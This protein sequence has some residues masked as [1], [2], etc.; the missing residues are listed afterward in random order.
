MAGVTHQTDAQTLFAHFDGIDA[1][2]DSYDAARYSV[3][4]AAELLRRFTRAERRIVAGK[5]L[6]AARVA[7]GQL[8]LR[9]GHRTAAEFLA[10]ETGDSVGDAKDL[11]A[12][13]ASLHHQPGLEEAFRG[14]K[15][16]RRRAALVSSAVKVN[17]GQE[18]RLV[19]GAERDTLTSLRGQC[20][21]A[22]AQGRSDQD[23]ARHDRALHT[24]RRCRTFTDAE[25][26]FR[27]DALLTPDVGARV[28]S[29]LEAQAHRYFDQ[30]R[31]TGRWET[32]DAYRADALVALVTGQGILAPRRRT[33]A[34]PGNA[35]PDNAT[36]DNGT[37]TDNAAATDATPTPT[38]RTPDPRATLFI[39][40]D[41][42]ALRRGRVEGDE[43]CEIPGVGPVPVRWVTE[44]LGTALTH[45]V[46]TDGVD[47]TTLYSPGRHL[48]A[49]IR[50]ALMERDS[51]CVVP[52][53]DAR[54]GLENDHWVTDFARGGRTSLDNLARLCRH[55]HRL[56]THRGFQLLGGP[57]KWQWVA[58][59]NPVVPPRPP[60]KRT[61]KA[62]TKTRAKS[63]PAPG[64]GP[65]LFDRRE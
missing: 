21:A 37:P 39:R 16:S 61:T 2:M 10:A 45:L 58:P 11:L 3:E 59:A 48:P 30:A 24:D 23:Q 29:A 22:K 1:F 62:K 63:P 47:V 43:L 4:D 40:A 42:D 9:T 65:P 25:G 56:R 50:A 64:P 44:Q 26:A 60:R 17:P 49:S 31:A 20:L 8:H 55:H 53:C 41:L 5:T 46:V 52:G 14:G 12:L 13:G 19:H 33:N 54:L 15:L 6:S 36:T 32:G 34:T 28:L 7:E 38:G 35:T 57:G 27:L 18:D 51:R